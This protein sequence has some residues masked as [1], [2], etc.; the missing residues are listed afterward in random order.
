M[1]VRANQRPGHDTASSLFTSA[2]S[3]QGHVCKT[4]LVVLGVEQISSLMA[5]LSSLGLTV[6]PISMPCT[7]AST[8][9]KSKLYAFDILTLDG[10]DLRPLPLSLRKTNLARLLARHSNRSNPRPPLF[11]RSTPSARTYANHAR[12]DSGQVALISKAAGR[13]HIQE[14]QSP[15]AHFLLG[16]LDAAFEQPLVRRQPCRAAE[17]A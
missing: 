8:M 7:R 6:F 10:K 16:H 17:L 2:T 4:L 1:A 5:K 13:G 9:T 11:E 14:R 3:V 15:I 12:E